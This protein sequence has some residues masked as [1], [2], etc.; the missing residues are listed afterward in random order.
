MKSLCPTITVG[1]ACHDHGKLVED[2]IDQY[3]LTNAGTMP[4]TP[5]AI[6]LL[7]SPAELGAA[8]A[9][10]RGL[11][12]AEAP[13]SVPDAYAIAAGAAEAKGLTYAT[14]PSVK[15]IWDGT[16]RW[17]HPYGAGTPSPAPAR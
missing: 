12:Q 3:L 4:G 8:V 7:D 6:N 16:L 11:T 17:N 9:G 15:A 5:V 14:A 10:G 2:V 1:L 13:A